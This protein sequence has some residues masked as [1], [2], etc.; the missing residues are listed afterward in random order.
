MAR[1]FPS[2]SLFVVLWGPPVSEHCGA[3][4]RQSPPTQRMRVVVVPL[5]LEPALRM[6]VTVVPSRPQP[7]LRMRVTVA[8]QTR[9]LSAL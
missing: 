2:E 3:P 8:S 6:R 9:Q 4:F 5:R 1:L 7:A